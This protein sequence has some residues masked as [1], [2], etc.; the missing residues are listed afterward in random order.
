MKLIKDTIFEETP[1]FSKTMRSKF[2]DV[3]VVHIFRIISTYSNDLVIFFPL[4]N[5]Y[6]STA[7]S[8]F[9]KHMNDNT[10]PKHKTT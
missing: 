5:Q 9:V 2:I 7:H 6:F 8:Q 10:Q 1:N 4:F 3:I